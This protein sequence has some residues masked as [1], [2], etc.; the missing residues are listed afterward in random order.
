MQTIGLFKRLVVITYDGLLLTSVA[1]F[2]SALLMGVFTWLGPDIFFAPADPA[3]PNL[4]ERSDLGRL[5]GGII[6]TINVICVS[7]FF[8][9]WFWTHGGQTLGMKAWNLYLI[10]PDGKFIDWSTALKR[11]LAAVVSWACL[12]LG[13]TWVLLDKQKRSWHDIFTNTK[14]VK[15][16]QQ[17]EQDKQKNLAKHRAKN[18]ARGK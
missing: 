12:G 6:V 18:A 17:G 3:N 10:K 7:F 16:K 2:S 13:F 14:I 5:V 15:S 1:F 9:G 11:Y 8:Y 4:L